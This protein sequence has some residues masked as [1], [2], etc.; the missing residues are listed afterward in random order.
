MMNR[1]LGAA[2]L[3]IGVSTTGAAQASKDARFKI[4]GT[5]I[6]E[7]AAARIPMPFGADGFEMTDQGEIDSRK[8]QQLLKKNG[9]AV[10][11]GRM[12]TITAIEFGD[13][14]IEVELDG[15]GK[16]K[17]A[18]YD[19]IEVGMG[20]QSA[21]VRKDETSQAKGSKIV[22]KF[23]KTVP[24]DISPA[25]LHELLGPALDFEKRNF[26]KT[27]MDSL[28][29]EY[30]EAVKIKEARIGMDGSTVIMALGRADKKTRDKDQQGV[31]QETWIYYGRGKK[32]T[33]V[34]FQNDVVIKIEAF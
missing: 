17:K 21:P 5:V 31:L 27:G 6:A 28:P 7:Q 13:N 9:Q 14:K 34:W 30:Q 4:L 23:A 16:N 22:L 15:G 24:P 19:R 29:P 33:F 11:P 26:M 2:I 20:G 1:I 32:A 25:L 12:L 18:W 3:V 10:E 8:M